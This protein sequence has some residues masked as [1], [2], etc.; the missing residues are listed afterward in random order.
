M[1]DLPFKVGEQLNYRV[2]LG[3][4]NVQVGTLTFEVKSR[5]RYFNRD[6]LMV[7]ASAQTGG[8]AAIAV[9]D[10]ITSY[11]DPTTLL[12]F[13]TELNISEGKYRDVRAFNLDQDR[14]AATSETPK[15]KI[16]VP[17]GTHDLISALYA[18]RT[19]DLTIQKSNAISMMATHRPLALLVKAARRETI[20]LN[21]RKISAIVLELRTDEPQPD[22]LQ[23]RIWIGDDARRLPLRITAVTD[24]G[25][26]RADLVILP[27][28]AR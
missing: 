21:G 14:G 27:A 8:P 11:V 2:Y 17:V 13:R 9:K 3:A 12:P 7:S 28:A 1:L 20:E 26:V 4:A 25:P 10:Q 6:G 18:I 23:V 15:E 24:L 16:E 22:R 5:G 19:F